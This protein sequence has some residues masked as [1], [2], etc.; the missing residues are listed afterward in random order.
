MQ[1]SIMT[2]CRDC[3]PNRISKAPRC[4]AFLFYQGFLKEV[5]RLQY[6]VNPYI[7]IGVGGGKIRRMEQ[8]GWFEK[9]AARA[10]R[11]ES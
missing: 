1:K 7:I 4:G 9:G 11:K 5:G 6:R 3:R 10:I 2:G 8:R